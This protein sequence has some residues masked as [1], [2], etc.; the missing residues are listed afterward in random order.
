LISYESFFTRKV[1]YPHSDYNLRFAR[2]DADI[3]PEILKTFKLR[4]ISI[5]A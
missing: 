3:V 2:E 5:A 4:I 1:I